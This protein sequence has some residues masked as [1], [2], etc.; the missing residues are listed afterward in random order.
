MVTECHV[1]LL[2]PVASHDSLV[3]EQE[4]ILLSGDNGFHEKEER[5]LEFGVEIIEEI[6]MLAL[7]DPLVAC[8]IA[9]ETRLLEGQ[10]VVERDDL[11][12]SAMDDKSRG[13]DEAEELVVGEEVFV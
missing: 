8:K 7:L 6:I 1:P 11:V 3:V 12:F 10:G 2:R 5:L 9:V 13:T 4:V